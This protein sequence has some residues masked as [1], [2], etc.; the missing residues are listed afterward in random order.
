MA[1]PVGGD[2]GLELH[3]GIDQFL[4]V[5]EGTAQVMMGDSADKLD[6]VKEVKDDYAIFVP[7]GKW[8]NI[9]NKGDKPLK[10]YSIYASAE[11]PHGTIHK[12]SRSPWKPNTTIDSRNSETC[13]LNKNARFYFV[14]QPVTQRPFLCNVNQRKT[15]MGT[16]YKIRCRHCGAQFEHYMQPGYGVLPMCVGCGEYVETE[17]AIRCPACLKKLNTTQ[18][19]FNEQIEVTY[20]WD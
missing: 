5:E 10:I 9:V 8:H 7:A 11:H 19:E 2:V 13:V 15:I 6:F 18:E 17:T 4:R 3:N 1:I 16:A 12:P 20:M 14:S